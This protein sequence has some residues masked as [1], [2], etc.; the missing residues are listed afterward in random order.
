MNT[1]TELKHIFEKRILRVKDE[2]HITTL[3][4]AVKL[5]QWGKHHPEEFYHFETYI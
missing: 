2:T 4:E 3:K 1:D 5:L